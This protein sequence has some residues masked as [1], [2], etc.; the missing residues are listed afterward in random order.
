MQ[1]SDS[2]HAE[3]NLKL[4]LM[5]QNQKQN[6]QELSL[7]HLLFHYRNFFL[8]FLYSHLMKSRSYIFYK[9]IYFKTV[10]FIFHLI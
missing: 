7:I 6:Y 2:N 3:Y 5:I 1:S 4:L 10:F 8:Y 9:I